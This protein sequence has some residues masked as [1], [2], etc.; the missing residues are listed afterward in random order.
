M[1][2]R[3]VVARGSSLSHTS[4][5]AK[6]KR[7]TSK[8][9]VKLVLVDDHPMWR[10]TLRN[11]L[12]HAKVGKVVGEASDGSEAVDV[13]RK[14]KADVV[15]MDV[16]LPTIDGIAATRRLLA[17]GSAA[18]VLVL[19]SSDDRGQVADAVRAGACGYMLKTAAPDEVVDAVRR[20]AA[21]ELVFPP[22]IAT[23]VLDELR[24]PEDRIRVVVGDGTIIGREGLSRV[25]SECGFDVRGT[26]SEA[27]ELLRLLDAEHADIAVVD[28]SFVATLSEIRERVPGKGLLVIANDPRPGD[29]GRLL[30]A[31]VRGVGYVLRERIADLGELT[32]A[33]Q[34]VAQGGSVVD[35]EIVGSLVG[36]PTRGIL[37]DLTPRE[38]EVL[39]LMAEGHSN[40]AIVERLVLGPKTVEGHV[41]SIFTKLGLEP[42]S[43]VHRR[44]RAVITYLRSR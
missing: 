15:V 11:I 14:T 38:I 43:D 34:R 37:D 36:Q 17:E 40:Q 23:A 29:V 5:V 3:S 12:T 44:V 26:A 24:E 16:N 30:S 42:A 13:A 21:G 31:D 19:A 10:D 9:V 8:P 41:R 4:G 20:V 32:D 6:T 1:P 18:K 25:L 27:D 28:A 7:K 39:S 35:P 22:S 33:V 2:P